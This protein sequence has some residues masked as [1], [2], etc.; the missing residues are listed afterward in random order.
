MILKAL[1]ILLLVATVLGGSAYFVYDLY[2][3]DK[4]LDLIEQTA[5]PTPVPTPTPDQSIAA[6]DAL[7]PTATKD[8]VEARESV[9]NFI[10]T[11]PDSVRLPEANAVLGRMNLVLFRDTAATPANTVYTVKKGDSLAKIASVTKSN[12]EQIYWINQLPSI[13][14]QI[15][16]QLL[17]PALNTSA[18]VN[19]EKSTIT[20]LNNGEFFKEYPIVSLTLTGAAAKGDFETKVADRVARKGET[21][22]AF[23]AKDYAETV[24]FVLLSPGGISIHP[25]PT[26]AADGT[27]PPNPTGIVL[28]LADFNDIFAL[29]KS[30][31][32]LTI[33]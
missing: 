13:N 9:K 6:W 4:K 32:P 31:T 20:V 5:P 26:P 1:T 7:K 18:V 30:G 17:I 2:Y 27:I 10:A 16:Q 11:F 33:K 8:T 24:R 15:G 23:G 22:V 25:A 28:N 29:L 19:R 21:R 3:K 12:V 14:L